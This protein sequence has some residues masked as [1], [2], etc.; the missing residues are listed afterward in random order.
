M[1]AV[2]VT[3]APKKWAIQWIEDNEDSNRCWYGGA[4]GC[5]G[6]NENINTGL[7]L[8]TI[9]LKNNIAQI[10]V[11]ATLLYDSIP[12]EEENETIVKAAALNKVIDTLEQES[13]SNKQS[14]EI[15]TT[16]NNKSKP[17]ILLVDHEDS[18]VHTLASYFRRAGADVET[19]RFN[20]AIESLKNGKYDLVVLSPGPGRPD[21]FF[22]K[23]TIG[24]C[25]EKKIPI[26]GVCL[27]LQGII[28]YF[29]GKLATLEIPFHGKT[30]I[31]NVSGE[32][33]LFI[34][35]EKSFCIGRYHSLYAKSIPKDIKVT[36][37]SDDG[38]VMA[39]EHTKLPI[40]AVQFH[41]ES[42]MTIDNEN[43]FKIIQ[44]VIQILESGM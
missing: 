21:D 8:R 26:F 4:V 41:P 18:F 1:W 40:Y 31:I 30:S 16:K 3:G 23:D 43:G 24:V 42:L 11:G 13:N 37:K 33:K 35:M 29:N 17:N 19:L 20:F 34:G 22:L 10:R 39:I 27:G 44:N 38:I 12:E 32:S 25:V 36:A 2:T 15:I 7:T 9:R 5:L 6:F 28:E 14:Q